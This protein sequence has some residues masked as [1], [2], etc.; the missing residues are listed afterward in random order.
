MRVRGTHLRL[1]LVVMLLAAMAMVAVPTGAHAQRFEGCTLT[2]T[3]GDDV[4]N[5][6]SFADKICA[7]N[8]DDLVRGFGGND[9]LLGQGGND[10]VQG[11][12]GNDRVDGGTGNDSLNAGPGNDL[13]LGGD[14]NDTL[15]SADGVQ[16][17][18]DNDGG[19]GVDMCLI[20]LQIDLLD[21]HSSCLV[22]VGGG[23]V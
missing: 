18:D 9:V 11:G 23:P 19:A 2:G 22:S 5:G 15:N 3:N 14:G 21:L 16:G 10:N 6:T 7:K 17:N 1:V 8:G 4:L 20:I 13:N 12:P